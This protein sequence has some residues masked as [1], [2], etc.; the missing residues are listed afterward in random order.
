MNTSS[1]VRLISVAAAFAALLSSCPASDTP[2]VIKG[3]L[4]GAWMTPDGPWDGRAVLFLH[5]FADDMDGAGDLAKHTAQALAK[6]GIASL[7]INFRGEGDRH[8]TVIESTFLTRIEDTEAA[9]DFLAH[10]AGVKTDHLGCAGWSLGSA[11]ELEVLGRHP[12]WFRTGVVW[13]S[14]T[15]DMESLMM[16][17]MPGAKEAVKSG[18]STYDAGWKKITTYRAFY[19]S[20]KGIDVTRSVAKYPGALLALRGSMDFVPNGDADL[21]K[22]ATGEPREAILIGGADHIFNV[23]EPEKGYADRAIRITVGWFART[24]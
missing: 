3:D 23:F 13:S 15:G 1:F 17:I 18:V 10:T 12:A 16:A 8:R 7:R 2:V 24:L 19:E 14:P 20:F 6:S 9:Y 22:A 11:T 21:M 4:K 5:G